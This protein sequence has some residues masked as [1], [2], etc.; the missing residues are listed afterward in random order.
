VI[1][2]GGIS[3]KF[4]SPVRS[5]ERVRLQ[6]NGDTTQLERAMQMAEKRYH[7]NTLGTK[8]KLSFS[9][10]SDHEIGGRASKLGVSLGSNDSDVAHSILSLKQTEEDHRITYLKNNL[11]ESL[12]ENSEC[13]IMAT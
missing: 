5:S 8:S 2:F 4:S 10:F 1:A 3:E 7:T 11:N 6:H 9:A 13:S 12:N